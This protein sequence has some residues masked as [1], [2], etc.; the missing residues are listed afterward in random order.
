MTHN[1][2]VAE[3]IKDS[4]EKLGKHF[5]AQSELALEG[6]GFINKSYFDKVAK[7][8]AEWQEA[9]GK[10]VAHVSFMV[11]NNIRLTDTFEE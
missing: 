2:K 3:L 9:K 5:K 11:R 8:Y 4:A 10:E 7:T 6:V 1:D